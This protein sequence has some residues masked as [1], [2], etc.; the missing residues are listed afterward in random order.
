ML[1]I[2]S[3]V[4]CSAQEFLWNL[5]YSENDSVSNHGNVWREALG[6]RLS[7]LLREG[8]RGSLTETDWAGI[9]GALS[10]ARGA[11]LEPLFQIDPLW[12]VGR[13]NTSR[14]GE[15]RLI[16]HDPFRAIA[17]TLLLGDFVKALDAGRDTPGD[18]FA[19]RYRR[20]R[21]TFD[22]AK[23]RG[24]PAV[25]ATDLEGP[26]TEIDGLTR[27]SMIESMLTHGELAPASISL[28]VGVTER[29]RE[30]QWF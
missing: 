27:M 4:P 25:V 26:F 2:E 12:Y 6:P 9:R 5:A 7:R 14:L 1:E 29:I 20:L 19:G 30:W 23:S 21:A 8:A 3:P 24:I 13:A 28:L 18:R 16:R 15:I 10:V 17:P 22:P 11:Y